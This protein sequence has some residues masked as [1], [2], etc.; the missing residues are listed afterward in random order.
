MSFPIK[1]DTSACLQCGLCESAC[2]YQAIRMNTYPEIGESSCQLC[3]SCIEACPAEALSLAMEAESTAIPSTKTSANGIWVL[4]ECFQDDLVPVT[5]ELLGE[6]RRLAEVQPQ[7]VSAVLLGVYTME[8]V[9]QLFAAGADTVY[10]VERPAL[11]TFI[12]DHNA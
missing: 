12:E 3:K 5:F 10:H 1:L 9:N 8:R 4:A 6:A 11:N 7:P 2:L